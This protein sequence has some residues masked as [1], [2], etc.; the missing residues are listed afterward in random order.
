MPETSLTLLEKLQS[1]ANHRSWP[2]FVELYTPLIRGWLECYALPS[3]DI[4]DVTQEVMMALVR[5]LPGFR[6]HR[7]GSFRHWLKMIAVNRLRWFW[8]NRGLQAKA[9][10]GSDFLQM[11][12]QLEDPASQ[13]SDQ[14][15][16]DHDRQIAQRLLVIIETEYEPKTWQAFR[17]QV[18]D[19]ARAALVAAELKISINA[20][21][22][23]KSR[24]LR[25]LREESGSFC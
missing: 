21:L 9:I 10:G 15:D 14:W 23:A 7:M 1:G 4:D 17:R 3:S 8:R 6:R 19:G 16:R 13:L 22:L 25:R 5:E 24:I 18:L 12:E 2:R 11:L 20:A